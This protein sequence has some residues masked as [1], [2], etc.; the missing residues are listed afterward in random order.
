MAAVALVSVIGLA[1]DAYAGSCKTVNYFPGVVQV[2]GTAKG[3]ATADDSAYCTAVNACPSGARKVEVI[4]LGVASAAG[5]TVA[6]SST[7][8]LASGDEVSASCE[9]ALKAGK[10]GKA[11]AGACSQQAS[12]TETVTE[13][14][15]A[16]LVAAPANGSAAAN[17]TCFCGAD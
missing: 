1:P 13:A 10:T 15:C 7:G 12:A 4:G 17:A 9:A 6:V 16:L 5:S 8:K 3:T 14:D 2:F 11:L